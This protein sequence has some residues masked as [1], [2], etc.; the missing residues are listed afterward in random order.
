MKGYLW[1]V[2]VYFPMPLIQ[3]P[4]LQ[5][6]LCLLAVLFSR[7]SR[8]VLHHLGTLHRGVPVTHSG[9]LTPRS[10]V[11]TTS[12][13]NLSSV[14]YTRGNAFYGLWYF[15][16][17]CLDFLLFFFLLTVAV[18]EAADV[19]WDLWTDNPESISEMISGL[20]SSQLFFFL[21]R[22]PWETLLC[23]I[24]N[25]LA[26]HCP[27][28]LRVTCKPKYSNFWIWMKLLKPG[29]ALVP[30]DSQY[31]FFQWNASF[32]ISQLPIHDW[33]DS[34]ISCWFDF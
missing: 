1:V 20:P 11:D 28:K 14:V 24:S 13:L 33:M 4:F 6:N 23:S 10:A 25:S 18:Y 7:L 3:I 2:C 34:E 21:L 5:I 17:Q 29:P 19:F 31:Y 26:F 27:E 30:E 22:P 15:S 32:L 16:W 9:S 8:W 12:S